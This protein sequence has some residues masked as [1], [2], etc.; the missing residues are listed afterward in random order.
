MISEVPVNLCRICRNFNENLHRCENLT[1]AGLAGNNC[2][3]KVLVTEC[4]AYEDISG[5]RRIPLFEGRGKV[6]DK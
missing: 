5:S 3:Y 2:A 6:S 1:L 4:P